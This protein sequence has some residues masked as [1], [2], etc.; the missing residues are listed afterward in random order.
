[1]NT[2]TP[3]RVSGIKVAGRYSGEPSPPG[4]LLSPSPPLDAS[5]DDAAPPVAGDAPGGGGS[6]GTVPPTAGAS[7]GTAT[8]VGE[9]VSALPSDRPRSTGLFP[10]AVFGGGGFEPRSVGP[11]SF[12]LLIPSA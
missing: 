3:T 4:E 12:P 6:D 10:S 2:T 5:P 7:K 9:N 8:A 11:L 1:M